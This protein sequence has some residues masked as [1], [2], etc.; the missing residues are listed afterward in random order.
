M[1]AKSQDAYNLS[2]YTTLAVGME[3]TSNSL[4]NSPPLFD[5]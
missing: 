1:L 2:Y 3:V 4:I 5:D